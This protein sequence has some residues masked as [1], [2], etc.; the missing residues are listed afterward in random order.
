VLKA[1][2]HRKNGAV[3]RCYRL[4]TLVRSIM[5][6]HVLRTIHT[7]WLREN[8]QNRLIQLILK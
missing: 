8:Y 6:M 5:K 4:I 2:K 1:N 3:L 7:G